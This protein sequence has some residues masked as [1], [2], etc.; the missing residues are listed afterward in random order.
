MY[1]KI[2]REQRGKKKETRIGEKKHGGREDITKL[3]TEEKRPAP[4]F[5]KR[6]LR[7]IERVTGGI[8]IRTTDNLKQALLPKRRK[9]ASFFSRICAIHSVRVKIPI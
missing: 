2:R 7:I 9:K 3:N 1:I 5:I 4:E 6:Y 8:E